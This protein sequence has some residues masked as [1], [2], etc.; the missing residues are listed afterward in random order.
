VRLAAIAQDRLGYQE[1]LDIRDSIDRNISMTYAKLQRKDGGGAGRRK[2]KDKEK[3]RSLFEGRD[4][5]GEVGNGNGIGSAGGGGSAGSGMGINGMGEI[6]PAA[7]GLGPDE[8]NR[9]VVSEQLRKLVETRRQWVDVVGGVYEE[10]QKE[11]P[12]RIR[13]FP[14]KSV[15]TGVEEE[16]RE[17]VVMGAETRTNGGMGN[18]TVVGLGGSNGKGKEKATGDEMDIG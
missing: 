14:P 1:Y 18:V 2:K 6:P 10:K 16:N 17:D 13:G 9:L 3:E 8:H 12:G 7:R 4:V 11:C 5:S 15:Y